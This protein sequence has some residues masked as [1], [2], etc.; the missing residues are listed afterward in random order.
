MKQQVKTEQKVNSRKKQA[1]QK[2]N[3][4]SK[5]NR[6]AEWEKLNK[7]FP[8]VQWFSWESKEENLA[9]YWGCSVVYFEMWYSAGRSKSR[10]ALMIIFFGNQKS[11]VATMT[12]IMWNT[13]YCSTGRSSNHRLWCNSV[14]YLS[15]IFGVSKK[16]V[17]TFK[18]YDWNDV[19]GSR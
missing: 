4:R 18:K 8:C 7:L 5:D 19:C 3:E 11:A 14:I 9:A 17:F 10:A 16:I 2:K 6:N 12:F 1:R 13:Q 15:I